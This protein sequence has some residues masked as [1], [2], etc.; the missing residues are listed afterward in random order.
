VPDLE[1][2]KTKAILNNPLNKKRR[3]TTI[4]FLSGGFKFSLE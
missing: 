4:G 1:D 3:E 2:A